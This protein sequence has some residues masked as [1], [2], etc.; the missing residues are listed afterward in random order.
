MAAFTRNEVME[1]ARKIAEMIAET[2]EVDYFKKAE[3]Q[4]NEN[5][6]IQELIK[7]IKAVQKQAVNLQH[8]GK[9]EALQKCEERLDRLFEELDDIPVVQEFKS[10]QNDV[11]DLLQIVATTISSKVTAHVIESTD[12]DVINGLTGSALKNEKSCETAE[13]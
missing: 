5:T 6:K 2:P 10:S 12:G 3:Q 1:Q 9:G 11:N 8:Y 13:K 7:Q 4:I